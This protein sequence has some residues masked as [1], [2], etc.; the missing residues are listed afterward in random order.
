MEKMDQMEFPKGVIGAHIRK[1]RKDKGMTVDEVAKRT[2]VS[3]SMVSQIENGLTNPSLDTLWKIS[4][5]LG[6]PV[7]SFF[8]EL[9][10][11]DVK[12]TKRDDQR[13]MK[14]LHPNVIYRI[15]SPALE[16]GL[17]VFELIVQP[18]EARHFPQLEHQGEE[19]GYLIQ[20]RLEVI[21]EDRVHALETG[22]SIYFNSGQRHKFN[23]PGTEQAIGLWVMISKN[24]SVGA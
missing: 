8:K 4:H 11:L 5:C 7:F 1:I 13:L 22:D 16:N 6:V 17:E 15:L 10:G 14:M 9:S 23:N 24:G 18:G 21:I 20:G 2:G 19:F 3:Q 12:I